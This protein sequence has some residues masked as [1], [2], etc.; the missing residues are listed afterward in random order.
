MKKEYIYLALILLGACIVRLYRFNNPIADWH[1]WRQADTS[2]VS[3]NFAKNGIDVLHPKFDDLSNVSSGKDNPLGYRFVEFPIYNVLQVFVY[4]TFGFFTIE[5]AGRLVTIFS[6]LSSVLFIYLLVKKHLNVWAG[7]MS[8][9][10]YSFIPYSIYYGRTILPDTTTAMATLGSINFF[11]TWLE[12]KSNIFFTLSLLFTASAF[13]LKP[14]A[15]FFTVPMVYLAYQKFGFSFFN[16]KQLW[17][18]V[19][20]SLLPLVLWR[21]WMT[22]FPE[23]IP[24]NAWLLNGNGIRFR[25]SFFRWILYERITKLISGYAGILLFILGIFKSYN[26]KDRLF[27]YSFLVSSII[28][29]C[30]FATGNVQHDYYQILILPTIAIFMGIGTVY[31]FLYI[32]RFSNNIIA[33]LMVL[34]LVYCTFFFSWQMVKDYFNINNP[35]MVAVGVS[36][37][38]LIPQDAKIIAPLNGDTSFLYQTKRQGWASFEKPLPEMVDLLEADFLVL[39]N[40]KKEDFTGIGRS[41]KVVAS[42]NSYVLFDLRKKP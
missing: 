24:V 14:Y 42:T 33:S 1:A 21:K 2:S 8:A 4:K 35:A 5:E 9:F 25:P 3:R 28:Y 15:L 30:V 16:K 26:L 7:L 10:I 27:F 36:I 18:F 12:E 31:L 23:G 38:R 6:S 32:K 34:L 37:D 11:N 41:Y 22:Q 20:F 17:I 40:P 13:L 29:V 39:L 19:I